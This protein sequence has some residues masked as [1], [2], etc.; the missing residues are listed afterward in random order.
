MI[1]GDD[2]SIKELFSI[3]KIKLYANDFLHCI[4]IHVSATIGYS[5]VYKRE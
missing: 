4:L 1:Y 5:K 3:Y 2:V